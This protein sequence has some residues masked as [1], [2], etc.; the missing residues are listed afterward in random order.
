MHQLDKMRNQENAFTIFDR[1]IIF[2]QT[3]F[4]IKK[5]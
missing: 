3:V 2:N 1:N 4:Y 5:K